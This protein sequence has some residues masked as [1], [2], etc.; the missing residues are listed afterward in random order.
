MPSR[1]ATHIRENPDKIG[2]YKREELNERANNAVLR[3]CPW[4]TTD[5]DRKIARIYHPS[6]K[7]VHNHPANKK[8]GKHWVIEFESWGVFKSPLMGWST[9]SLDTFSDLTMKVS[10]LDAAI[11]IC[12]MKGW[13]YD[14]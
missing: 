3:S 9:A 13:G 11:A 14:V 10:T 5:Y 7:H 12:E 8:I 6:K 2:K 1:D 4:E